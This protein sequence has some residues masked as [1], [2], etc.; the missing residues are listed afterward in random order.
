MCTVYC[1]SHTGDERGRCKAR[2]I[3]GRETRGGRNCCPPSSW[4]YLHVLCSVSLMQPPPDLR[5]FQLPSW[6]HFS[7]TA[8]GLP[9]VHPQQNPTGLSPLPL[10]PGQ[11]VIVAMPVTTLGRQAAL[12][13]FSCLL[14][15]YLPHLLWCPLLLTSQ[16]GAARDHMQTP[17]TLQPVPSS[18]TGALWKSHLC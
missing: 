16:P 12:R 18:Q 17:S 15:T 13:L 10:F 5:A 11:L 7:R 14:I 9:P 2:L 1:H 3:I 4:V 8:S 6:L